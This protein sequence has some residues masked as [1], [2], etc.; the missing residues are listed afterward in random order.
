[1][2]RIDNDDNTI[3][4]VEGFENGDNNKKYH[5]YYFDFIKD[6]PVKVAEINRY[7][8]P[9]N[10]I[11]IR[12]R[13]ICYPDE[14]DGVWTI[15]VV[16]IDSNKKTTIKTHEGTNT[17]FVCSNGKYIAWAEFIGNFNPDDKLYIFDIEENKITLIDTGIDF[18][19]FSQDNLIY[20]KS[21]DLYVY[22][23][24]NREKSC[25]TADRDE[26]F[27]G[28]NC[29]KGRIVCSV[30]DPDEGCKILI[31]EAVEQ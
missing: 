6:E 15:N 27:F 14:I 9:F 26:Y 8:N 5:V 22:N 31:L 13:N 11:H 20:S 1:M 4:W 12:N 2:P 30:N 28:F 7:Y 18:F 29:H 17:E 24:K 23:T 25:I 16:D 3:T 21:G 10:V 19:D